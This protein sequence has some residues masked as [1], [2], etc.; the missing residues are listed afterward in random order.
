MVQPIKAFLFSD[1]TDPD[2][3]EN[4]NRYAILA[5]LDPKDAIRQLLRQELP[6][7]IAKL[8]AESQDNSEKNPGPQENVD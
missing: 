8:E 4:T 2:I 3:L 6:V 5:S 1:T 7:R